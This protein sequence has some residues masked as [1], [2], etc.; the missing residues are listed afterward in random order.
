MSGQPVGKHPHQLLFLRIEPLRH[1]AGVRQRPGRIDVD[2][3]DIFLPQVVP[4]LRDQPVGETGGKLPVVEQPYPHI[5]PAR[6]F[7]DKAKIRPPFVLAEMRMDPAFHAEF[8]NVAA[9]HGIDFL[10][11]HCVIL[12]MLPEKRQHVAA[13]LSAQAF[14]QPCI[15]TTPSSLSAVCLQYKQPFRHRQAVRAFWQFSRMTTQQ[16]T[17]KAPAELCRRFSF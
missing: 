9:L 5:P 15:H 13:L 17:E 4:P 11:Q 16:S 1:H 10:P 7:E 2:L 3:P 8:V 6:L 12:P 14:L